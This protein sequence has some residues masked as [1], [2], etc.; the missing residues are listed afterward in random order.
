MFLDRD[1][2]INVEKNY[3][4]KREEFEFIDGVFEALRDMQARGYLLI[5]VT[6]Q[7][8]IGRGYY[9]EAD[10]QTLTEWMF[11]QFAQQGVRIDGVYHSPYHPEH[12]IGRY[13]KESDCRK[14]NPGMILQAADEH[15]ID[16]SRSILVG[17]KESD[18]EAGQRAGVGT[19]VLVR[20]GHSIDEAHT[21]ADVVLDSIS[22]MP[23][24]AANTRS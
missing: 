21:R 10:F 14:P 12:G 15:Q 17:D 24:W 16:L 1:G 3:L 2:V 18:I 19:T 9:T 11:E 8:G 7:A 22:Q 23:A 4:Y 13:R 20:S 5:V 6:N